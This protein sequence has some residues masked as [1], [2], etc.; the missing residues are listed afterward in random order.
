[1]T[2]VCILL[3]TDAAA[4]QGFLAMVVSDCC[5]DYPEA[6]AIALKRYNGFLFDS[7]KLDEIR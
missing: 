3:T 6:H 2:S 7:V 1:M 4:Q 5:A